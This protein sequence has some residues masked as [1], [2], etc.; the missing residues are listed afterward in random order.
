M[1]YFRIFTFFPL[2]ISLNLKTNISAAVYLIT[3]SVVELSRGFGTK[4]RNL[5]LSPQRAEG[6]KNYT[7]EFKTKR[8][9]LQGKECKGEREN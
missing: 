1:N 5:F 6:H 7:E 3:D 4:N 9:E 8:K 2:N